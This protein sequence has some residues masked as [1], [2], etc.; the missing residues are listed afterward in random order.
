MEIL[1]DAIERAP[2]EREAW[3]AVACAGDEALYKEVARLL[4][5]EKTAHGFMEESPFGK[6]VRLGEE[7]SPFVGRRVGAY[8]IVEEIGRGGMGAVYLA[9][10][11]DEQFQSLVA[12]KVIKRGMDT[13][14]ILR[15]FRNERQILADLNHPNVARL[16]DGG[17]T[18]DGRPY[19]VM[20][21]VEGRSLKKYCDDER[22]SIKE[23][24]R[25]F[26]KVCSAVSYAHR[27]L[28]VH[29]DLK[30]SNILVTEDGEPKL[31][32][33]GIA[34]VLSPSASGQEKTA[35]S[36]RAMTPEYA[37]P[38]QVRGQTVT[39][40][41][42]IYSLG[43]ILYELLTGQR[44]YSFE[45]RSQAEVAKIITEREPEKPS[46]AVSH[47]EETGGG[48]AE[49]VSSLRD[50]KPSELRRRLRG[51]LDNIVLK[52]MRKEPERRYSSVEQFSE[53]IARHLEGLPVGARKDTFTYRASK[54]VKRNRVGVA[55]AAITLLTLVGGIVATAWEAH[56][57]RAERARA[58]QRF[59]QVRKLAHS[60]MFDYHDEI[61]ALPGSTK[62]RERLVK[63]ALEYLDSLSQDAGNDPSLMRELAAAYERV[64][65][66]QGGA[67]GTE[68]HALTSMSN[69]G[70]TQGAIASQAKSVAIRERLAALEPGNRDAQYEL[71]LSYLGMSSDLFFSSPEESVE[72]DRKAI[73]ILEALLAADPAKETLQYR[74]ATTYL[75]IA[76][77]LGNPAVPNLGDTKGASEFMSKAQALTEK[78]AADH[79][80]NVDYQM[81]LG[82][83]YNSSGLMLQADGKLKESLDAYE[84]AAAVDERLV[85]Q[86]GANTLYRREL[87]AQVGNAGS[88][89]LKLG[90]SSGALER[91]RR[92]QAIY[93][94]LAA[95]D[96]ND[97]SI[98]RNYAVGYRNLGAALGATGDRAAAIENFHKAQQIFAEL[99]SKDPNNADFRRQWAYVYLVTSRFQSEAKDLNGAINSALQGIKIDEALV[100]ASPTN[101]T[102]RSTLAQL[103]SQLGASHAALATRVNAGEQAEQWRAARDAYQKSLDIYQGMKGEG[104][105]SSADAGKPDEVLGQI[106]KCDAALKKLGA[107]PLRS[108]NP[109]SSRLTAV[110]RE[111]NYPVTAS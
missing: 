94:S 99:V 5:H 54:F 10:R 9:R 26:L 18:G 85:E 70:D 52:A 108:R 80:T 81:L 58:E 97:A 65:A 75:S 69:L 25:L 59:N 100:A 4:S 62:V 40:A 3:L 103:Y 78:L 55:A 30:P 71:A 17:T 87:A 47:A 84:R 23:R 63:D 68:S 24:L 32:D 49:E 104:T 37:S 110:F 76:K 33:F 48:T 61:A 105:L 57:A 31:L 11:A 88:T 60:V 86:D 35:T 39:T 111:R 6:V 72:Y 74:L 15:T 83:L 92:A 2:A 95:A 20:E 7:E 77:S 27:N 98:R 82:S 102:A 91:F 38:E 90:D 89:M 66:V 45:G 41:T 21:Y 1:G 8:E 42:D 19:F 96:P 64:A 51:D 73:P 44:P 36:V 22:L 50:T 29:R 12:V 13:D 53:D 56:T 106:A 43:V 14:D 101:A 28:I 67:A 16:L 93:E 79:P 46:T 34:K 107:G 109:K